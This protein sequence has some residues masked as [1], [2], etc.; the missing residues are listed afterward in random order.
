MNVDHLII[1]Y[2]VARLTETNRDR[3][4]AIAIDPGAHRPL[5]LGDGPYRRQWVQ[6]EVANLAEDEAATPGAARLAVL[7]RLHLRDCDY[8]DKHL[9]RWLELYFAYAAQRA[10]EL[11]SSH[12]APSPAAGGSLDPLLWAMAALRPLPRAHLPTADGGHVAVEVALWDGAA[13]TAIVFTDS[14]KARRAPGR[15]DHARVLTVDPP[16]SRDAP[17]VIGAQLGEG[18]FAAMDALAV[19]PDP[20]GPAPFRH[21]AARPPAF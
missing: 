7:R 1:R 19:P 10:S 20:F 5:R 4:P 14:D 17:T 11:A 21:T 3:A 13:V 2:G 12:A 6:E 18:M 9:R 8:L 15:A 16:D